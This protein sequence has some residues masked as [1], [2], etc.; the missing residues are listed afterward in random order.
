MRQLEGCHFRKQRPKS[1]RSVAPCIASA[2]KQ[3]IS[4]LYGEVCNAAV[5]TKRPRIDSDA[6]KVLLDFQ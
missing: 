5:A 4:T 1:A 3:P 6:H 2:L